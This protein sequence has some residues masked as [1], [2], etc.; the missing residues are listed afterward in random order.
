M[1]L[2]MRN[3]MTFAIDILNHV[4]KIIAETELHYYLL[5]CFVIKKIRKINFVNMVQN[6]VEVII[7]LWIIWILTHLIT[8]N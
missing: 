8:V 1:T 6:S 4:F 5:Y 2:H 3:S 7:K